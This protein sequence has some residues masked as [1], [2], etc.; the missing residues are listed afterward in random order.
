M[1]EKYDGKTLEEALPDKVVSNEQGECYKISTLCV[2]TFKKVGYEES[3]RVLISDLKVLAGIGPVSEQSLE[4]QGYETIEDL[5]RH[6][7]W[8]NQ[9]HDYLKMIDNKEVDSIQKWLW[10][11]LPRSHPLLHYLAG[12]CQDHDLTIMGLLIL[13]GWG[14]EWLLKQSGTANIRSKRLSNSTLQV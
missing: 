10:Q 7:R 5:E 3:R 9:A 1:L 13:N 8:K 6:P 14:S 11:R 2:S 4:K 12:F